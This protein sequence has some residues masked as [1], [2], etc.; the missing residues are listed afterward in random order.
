MFGHNTLF[1]RQIAS[2]GSGHRIE[3]AT[4]FSDRDVQL[5]LALAA[6]AGTADLSGTSRKS[7]CW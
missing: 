7:G 3:S 4:G 1:L 6:R 5:N 2:V